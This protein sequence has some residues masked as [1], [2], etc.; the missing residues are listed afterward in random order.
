MTR[1]CAVILICLWAGRGAAEVTDP[2]RAVFEGL[3]DAPGHVVIGSDAA[4]VS[5]FPCQSCHRRDGRGGGEGDAPPIT[6]EVLTRPSGTRPA[7]DARSFAHLLATGEAPSGRRISRLMPRYAFDE[8]TVTSLIAHLSALTAEQRTGIFPDRI[9]FGVPVPDNEVTDG[10]LLIQSL[11]T[12]LAAKMPPNGLHGRRVEIRPLRGDA[13][14]I[15]NRAR[16]ETVAILSPPPSRD[17]DRSLFTE[18]GVPVLF[19]L[20]SVSETEDP[21]LVRSLYASRERVVEQLVRKAISDGCQQVAIAAA[22]PA[23]VAEVRARLPQP[24]MAKIT[25]SNRASDCILIVGGDVGPEVRDTARAIYILSEEVTGLQAMLRGFRGTIVV[26]RHEST[27]LGLAEARKIGPLEAHAML[28][29]AALHDAL[30]SAG[31]DLTRT[32]LISEIGAVS[33][34]DLGLEFSGN[35]PVG[36]DKVVFQ[37]FEV[38]GEPVP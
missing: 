10:H 1:L 15:L 16:T 6:W 37:V 19:P 31:R 23:K 14:S 21:A 3:P 33:R 12:A 22:T 11:E 28:I 8:G 7:Y 17:F 34:H 26:G 38:R 25:S 20:E 36:S 30:T 5:R 2:G 13:A 27:A 4:A 9:V 29:A 32:S 24:D 35:R 18:A